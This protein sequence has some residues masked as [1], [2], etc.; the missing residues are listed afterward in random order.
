MPVQLMQK[1]KTGLVKATSVR[2]VR[3]PP[4][5]VVVVECAVSKELPDF[6]LE[7][8]DNSPQGVLPSR[9]FNKSGKSGLINMTPL[10][11]SWQLL[12]SRLR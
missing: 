6:I 7:P 8:V 4:L 2:R 1:D 5:S 11:G 3:L 9:S 12:P 10:D